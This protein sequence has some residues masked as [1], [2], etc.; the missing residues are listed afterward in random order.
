MGYKKAD[1]V[2]PEEL[3]AQIQKYVDGENIYIPK[4]KNTRRKWGR[5][6]GIYRELEKRNRSIQKDYEKGYS[7]VE[8]SKKYFL[9]EKSIQRIIYSKK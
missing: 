7:V 8:L 6:T 1:D 3:L 2:L 5:R 4:K 9:S